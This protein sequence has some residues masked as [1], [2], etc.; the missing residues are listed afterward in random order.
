MENRERLNEIS[1]KIVF[2]KVKVTD[3]SYIVDVILLHTLQY[4]K[5]CKT[6]YAFGCFF[7]L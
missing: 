1:K 5:K 6:F 3:A 4:C 7:L 2:K